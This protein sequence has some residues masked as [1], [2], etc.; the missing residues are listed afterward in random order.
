MGAG[1]LRALPVVEVSV[2]DTGRLSRW[3]QIEGIFVW[4]GIGAPGSGARPAP[5]IETTNEVV[6]EMHGVEDA[7]QRRFSSRAFPERPM[8]GTVMKTKRAK[9]S[10]GARE[11]TRRHLREAPKSSSFRALALYFFWGAGLD[12]SAA[13]AACSC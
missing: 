7:A 11:S 9:K 10:A 2:A 5:T 12:P 1:C 6:R 13:C 4:C 3:P 8:E